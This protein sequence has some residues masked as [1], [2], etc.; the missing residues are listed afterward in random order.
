MCCYRCCCC[1][2]KCTGLDKE[3][4]IK[5]VNRLFYS[6]TDSIIQKLRIK[7]KTLLSLQFSQNFVLNLDTINKSKYLSYSV[8]KDMIFVLLILNGEVGTITTDTFLR[9][10]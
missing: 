8:Y 10:Q 4:R 3:L 1:N 2:D 5:P 6:G 7:R 9:A